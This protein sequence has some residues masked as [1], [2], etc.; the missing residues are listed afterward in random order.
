MS[1]EKP[2]LTGFSCLVVEDTE[3][4]SD[5]VSHVVALMIS[6]VEVPEI[7]RSVLLSKDNIQLE[8]LSFL[9]KRVHEMKRRARAE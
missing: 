9:L 7:L 5:L 6:A 1:D 4:K 3:K 2:D 8:N